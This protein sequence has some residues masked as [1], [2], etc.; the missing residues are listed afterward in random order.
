MFVLMVIEKH[1]AALIWQTTWKILL[2]TE[3]GQSYKA[4]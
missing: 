1:K 3:T 2:G 4:V